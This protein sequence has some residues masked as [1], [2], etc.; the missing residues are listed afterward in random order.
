MARKKD[1]GKAVK[2]RGTKPERKAAR[3]ATAL[4]GQGPVHPH[5]TDL[6]SKGEGKRRYGPRRSG[7]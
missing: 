3:R 1:G 6:A 4:E 2:G 5:R 7:R